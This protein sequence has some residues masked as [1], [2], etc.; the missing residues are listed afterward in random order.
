VRTAFFHIGQV[1]L[2]GLGTDR[3]RWD[4]SVQSSGQT[5]ARAVPLDRNL[6]VLTNS[7]ARCGDVSTCAVIGHALA[8]RLGPSLDFSHGARTYAG[9]PDCVTCSHTFPPRKSLE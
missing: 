6:P 4:V 3:L 5:T 1:R 9:A 7:K 8:G 2:V